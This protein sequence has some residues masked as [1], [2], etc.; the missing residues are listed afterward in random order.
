MLVTHDREFLDNVVTSS[1]VFEGEGQISE[2]VGGYQEWLR[3]GGSWD[4]IAAPHRG[5]SQGAGVSDDAQSKPYSGAKRKSEEAR[6]SRKKL[7]YKLQKELDS[8][9]Q[10][11]ETLEQALTEH[12]KEAS[13]TG[14][15]QQAPD[16]VQEK[17][18]ALAKVEAQLQDAY[19]RWE[20]LEGMQ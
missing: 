17:L 9:P 1:F 4:A 13:S 7:S 11:I 20:E 3:Q 18:A 14:F 6:S 15:Y 12:N 16:K 10:K 5:G 19:A 8:M 2:Y